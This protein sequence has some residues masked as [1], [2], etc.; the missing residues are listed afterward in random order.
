MTTAQIRAIIE[1]RKYR[2]QF[3]R[4]VKLYV[5]EMLNMLDIM[6]PDAEFEEALDIQNAI[7]RIGGA[8]HIASDRII[9]ERLLP[10]AEADRAKRKGEAPPP[11][12]SA[13]RLQK[14]AC[15]QA[16][17]MVMEAALF[18]ER[19]ARR[20]AKVAMKDGRGISNK[21]IARV[22]QEGYLIANENEYEYRGGMV[23]AR[24]KVAGKK[25][26][27]PRVIAVDC[28]T[29][30]RTAGFIKVWP[31]KEIESGVHRIE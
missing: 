24:Y 3:D 29:W 5:V 4:G 28:P 7:I 9:Y 6:Y 31:P 12:Y 11:W 1:P 26:V 2:R 22:R 23:I 10:R 27:E 13:M 15:E 30:L 20:G 19:L 8:R 16:E 14:E 25:S 18:L 17:L 21:F